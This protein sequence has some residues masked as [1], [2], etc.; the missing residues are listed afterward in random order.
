[1]VL[2]IR[3]NGVGFAVPEDWIELARQGHLGLVGIQERAEAIGGQVGIQSRVGEGTSIQ[4]T[5]S[6][7]PGETR[8]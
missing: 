3:D 5:V 4:V 6:I 7:V 2:E 1:V 8:E